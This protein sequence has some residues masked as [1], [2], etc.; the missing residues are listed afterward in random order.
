MKPKSDS[1]GFPIA[2]FQGLDHLIIR[3]VY[4]VPKH[5]SIQCSFKIYGVPMLL[6]HVPTWLHLWVLLPKLD[7][8]LGVTFEVDRKMY[9]VKPCD[10]KD[11]ACYAQAKR[12]FI[13]R[14]VL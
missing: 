1:K 8:I 10:G 12:H 2:F 14:K 3:V 7:R 13:K 11:F 4:Q 5:P 9:V 6:V